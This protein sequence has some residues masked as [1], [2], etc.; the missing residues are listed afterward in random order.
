MTTDG[1]PA[2]ALLPTTVSAQK[3]RLEGHPT[4]DPQF[5]RSML[6]LFR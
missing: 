6:Q 2:D 1:N 5:T 3:H 4:E